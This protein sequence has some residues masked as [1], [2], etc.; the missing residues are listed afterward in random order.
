MNIEWLN[1]L[2]AEGCLHR[3]E[4]YPLSISGLCSDRAK[5]FFWRHERLPLP[6]AYL[7]DADLVAALAQAIHLA[8]D[9]GEALRSAAWALA[10]HAVVPAAPADKPLN[11]QQKA[12]VRKFAESL[13]P[14][15][16]YWASL[17][18]PFRRLMAELPDDTSTTDGATIYGVKQLPD[19]RAL[20]KRSALAA[21]ISAIDGLDRSARTLR[22]IAKAEESLR[23]ALHRTLEAPIEER[24]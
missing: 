12:E 21:F 20:L 17:D 23:L 19:W 1:D 2:V 15:R 14:G 3:S 24:R 13:A 4:A 10:R 22:A 5:V 7:D 8:E 6:L 16:V 18:S 9:V 11:K